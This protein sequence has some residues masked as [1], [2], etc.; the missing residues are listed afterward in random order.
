MYNIISASKSA[1]RHEP[2]IIFLTDG[3]PTVGETNTK[4]I[5]SAV[6]KLNTKKTAIFSL[7]FGM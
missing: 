2:M 4:N 6:T 5:L 1:I 7:A 3:D